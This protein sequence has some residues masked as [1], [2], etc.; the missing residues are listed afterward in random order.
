MKQHQ[1]NRRGFIKKS[2]VSGAGSGVLLSTSGL[3]AQQSPTE[4][5]RAGKIPRRK[6]GKTGAEVPILGM[7]GSQRFDP[8]YDR[9]LHRAL[10]IGVDYFDTSETYSNGQSQKGLGVFVDQIGDRK[11]IWLTSKVA[12]R[13]F[14]GGGT[15]P[16]KHFSSH[17]EQNLEELRTDYLD[18]FFMHG[19]EDE[20]LL[21]PD[22]I[23][24]S[25]ELKKAGKIRFF[26]FSCHGGNVP[27]L[28]TKAARVGGIDAIMFRYSFRTYGDAAL[29]RAIDTAKEA[30]IGLIAMKTQAS[31]PEDHEKVLSFRSNQ[32][33]LPQAKLKAVWADD[34]IDAL[35][36]EMENVQML[37]ENG[38]AAV[39]PE[40]LAMDEFLQLNRLAAATAPVY[41]QGCSHI[42]ESRIDGQ[43]KVADTLRYLMY[44]DSYGDLDRARERYRR[45]SEAERRLD[46]VDLSAAMAA[47]PQGIDIAGRLEE[48]HRTLA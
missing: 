14:R 27:A 8:Q 4:L 36:S 24:M 12:P 21:E 1:L 44:G 39:T 5:L 17:L 22:Y 9:R 30:G 19:I 13:T 46:G 23:R 18:L 42:C 40:N 35:V 10:S 45:L 11:K 38:T 15:P 47:C 2:V 37:M 28:L 6:L 3:G 48:A 32:F 41:C 25:E 20:R 33:T 26:G 7:G 43:L 29:N 34:R 31:V 16:P